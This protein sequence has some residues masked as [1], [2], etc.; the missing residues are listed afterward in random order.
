[1]TRSK[2]SIQDVNDDTRLGDVHGFGSQSFTVLGVGGYNL[3]PSSTVGDFKKATSSFK[4]LK[5]ALARTDVNSKYVLS[6]FQA[7]WSGVGQPSKKR[8]AVDELQSAAGQGISAIEE[9][10]KQNRQDPEIN[11]L[12]APQ[13]IEGA[14]DTSSAPEIV[15]SRDETPEVDAMDRH[16]SATATATGAIAA[17]VQPFVVPD[18]TQNLSPNDKEINGPMLVLT[19]VVPVTP[20]IS[21]GASVFASRMVPAL[22]HEEQLADNYMGEQLP[23]SKANGTADIGSDGSLTYN[24]IVEEKASSPDQAGGG[25]EPRGGSRFTSVPLA[26]ASTPTFSQDQPVK[27]QDPR[28]ASRHP[29]KQPGLFRDHDMAM[30]HASA[31]D[32][33]NTNSRRIKSAAADALLNRDDSWSRWNPATQGVSMIDMPVD[34]TNFLRRDS[35]QTDT[36]LLGANPLQHTFSPSPFV[37]SSILGRFGT[38][39]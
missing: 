13:S 3:R 22:S 34:S 25:F 28:T 29:F 1:M 8:K 24:S 17:K 7:V 26:P 20:A 39:R 2:V 21:I 11:F 33:T 9:E 35:M 32:S 31:I 4:S 15:T 6:K 27:A 36:Q 30:L 18:Q 23:T 37:S 38:S 16:S 14:P 12:L 19:D 5:D 10:T